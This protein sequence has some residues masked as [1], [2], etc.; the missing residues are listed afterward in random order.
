MTVRVATHRNRGS[1][2][3]QRHASCATDLRLVSKTATFAFDLNYAG[4]AFTADV[5]S[6][7]ANV[8]P[9]YTSGTG[10]PQ[11]PGRIFFGGDSGSD[12]ITPVTVGPVFKDFQ[13]TVS[14]SSVIFGDFDNTGGPVTAAD[15]AIL[16]SNKERM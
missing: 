14:G 15:W 3:G 5:T 16:R 4:G 6:P 11:E 12:T 9:L 8:L 2:I 7:A 10:F 1:R 13:V